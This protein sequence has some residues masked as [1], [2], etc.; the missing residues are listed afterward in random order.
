MRACKMCLN[1]GRLS[2]ARNDVGTAI[3]RATEPGRNN[4]SIKEEG[5]V[6]ILL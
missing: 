1:T 3:S 5:K 2:I 6:A 4:S